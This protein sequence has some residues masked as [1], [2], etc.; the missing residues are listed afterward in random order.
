[1]KKVCF[2]SLESDITDYLIGSNSR[3]N[4]PLDT[5]EFDARMIVLIVKKHFGVKK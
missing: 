3:S 1:M 4:G 5:E 2:E